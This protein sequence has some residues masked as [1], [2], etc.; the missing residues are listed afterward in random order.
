M[1][2]HTQMQWIDFH[3]VMFVN[4]LQ[5]MQIYIFG[6]RANHRYKHIQV[7]LTLCRMH[8]FHLE[9]RSWHAVIQKMHI[10]FLRKLKQILSIVIIQR[11]KNILFS[12]QRIKF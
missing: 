6:S 7:L 3:V 12:A 4:P 1:A 10:N 5:S 8:L 2:K 11:L 9:K